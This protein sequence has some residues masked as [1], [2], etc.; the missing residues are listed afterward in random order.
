MRRLAVGSDR[1]AGNS[2]VVMPEPDQ[3]K[4]A[5]PRQEIDFCELPDG[6]LVET[7]S[8]P[9]RAGQT[10]LAVFRAGKLRVEQE[11][12]LKD[13][14]L[15]PL[16]P[17]IPGIRHINFASG[18]EKAQS[19]RDLLLDTAAV[20]NATMDVA[21]EQLVLIAAWVIGTYFVSKFPVAPY[22][23]FV[24][25]PGSGK[26]TALRALTLLCWRPL[27]TSDISSAAFYNLSEKVNT[28]LLIDEAATLANRRQIFHLLRAGSTPGFV[29]FRKNESFRSFGA[30]A[31]SWTEL[32]D[33]AA[34]NSRCLIIPMKCSS[35]RNLAP[36]T[37]PP[38]LEFARG[39]QRRLLYFR[40]RHYAE[41]KVEVIAGEG[42]L[43]P[44]SRDL[45]RCLA[46]PLRGCPEAI[47]E[48]ASILKEQEALRDMI[49]PQQA[50]V[51]GAVLKLSHRRNEG[52]W[53]IPFKNLKDIANEKLQAIGEPLFKSEKALGAE[54]TKLGFGE[55]KPTN[56]GTVLILTAEVR[57]SA[58][59]LRR[60]HNIELDN[61]E[62]EK[63]GCGLC[64][65]KAIP[66]AAPKAS[67]KG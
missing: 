29:T 49:S 11:L 17:S 51:I 55:R 67:N 37:H 62:S 9:E 13:R 14:T 56:S 22:L 2:V 59:E 25:S 61:S 46:A 48:L 53:Q 52:C 45:L 66:G 41:L 39:L 44:R 27:A 6:T 18:A 38:L 15:I 32:P 23:S 35:R 43:Q 60:I 30:R 28:T 58:H 36:V 50:A 34:L 65:P 24:G 12:R 8:D 10:A 33:D 57:R 1:L 16:E 64:N 7:I 42:T 20:L 63:D 5:K 21:P 47:K 54:L 3:K 19:A 40:W 31:F 26:T 4:P